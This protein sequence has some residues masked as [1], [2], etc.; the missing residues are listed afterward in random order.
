[1][2][3]SSFLEQNYYSYYSTLLAAPKRGA[4]LGGLLDYLCDGLG[5][6]DV[7]N[8]QVLGGKRWPATD[9]FFKGVIL[10]EKKIHEL[11]VTMP[12]S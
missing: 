5:I 3:L 1:M 11:K 6:E 8:L 4:E 7:T 9:Y 12:H 2:L 10:K